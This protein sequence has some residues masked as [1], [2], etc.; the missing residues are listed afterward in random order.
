MR[1][2]LQEQQWMENLSQLQ[3]TEWGWYDK[4]GRYFPILT[5]KAAAP[6]NIL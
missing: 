3:P 1:V 6:P 5:Y 2:Y 4:G